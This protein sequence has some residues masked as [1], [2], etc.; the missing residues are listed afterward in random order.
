MGKTP[1]LWY[2][3][4]MSVA[5]CR[6]HVST[7]ASPYARGCE[8]LEARSSL[9]SAS[10]DYAVYRA[11]LDTIAKGMEAR[12][13][14]AVDTV[15]AWGCVYPSADWWRKVR[16]GDRSYPFVVSFIE[17]RALAIRDSSLLAAWVLANRVAQHLEP[18]SLS[19]RTRLIML[20]RRRRSSGECWAL[21][22]QYDRPTGIIS[23]SRVGF[24]ASGSR[25]VVEVDESYCGMG[26]VGYYLLA[27]DSDGAWQ[28]RDYLQVLVS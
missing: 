24:S 28:V 5:G 17:Y 19:V 1:V 21:R 4:L 15:P 10:S 9:S 25:A 13:I 6:P 20:P 22:A 11:V 27:R 23:F 14:L 16:A 2:L 12:T 26:G 8:G 3:A 7:A 18:D